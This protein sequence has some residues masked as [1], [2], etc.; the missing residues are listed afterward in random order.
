MKVTFQQSGG[1]TGLTRRIELDTATLP[2]KEAKALQKAVAD[3]D[4]VEAPAAPAGRARDLMQYEIRVEKDDGAAVTV[5][6]NDSTV[7][8]QIYPLIQFLMD[9]AKPASLRRK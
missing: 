6:L 4:L 5:R 2:A 3:S 1:I 9:R 7:T 8:E